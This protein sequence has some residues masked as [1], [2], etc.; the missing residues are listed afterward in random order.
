MP[1]FISEELFKAQFDKLKEHYNQMTKENGNLAIRALLSHAIAGMIEGSEV[2]VQAARETLRKILNE[3]SASLNKDFSQFLFETQVIITLY[4]PANKP[5]EHLHDE[6]YRDPAGRDGV[7]L[8]Q[9]DIALV[10]CGQMS[11]RENLNC[12]YRTSS[13]YGVKEGVV[14]PRCPVTNAFLNDYEIN[15]L[16]KNGVNVLHVAPELLGIEER[17]FR[18]NMLSFNAEHQAEY[19]NERYRSIYKSV[20]TIVSNV[21]IVLTVLGISAVAFYFAPPLTPLIWISLFGS[22]AA[23]GIIDCIQKKEEESYFSVFSTSFVKS[24]AV[25]S[26]LLAGA[27]FFFPWVVGA[28]GMATGIANAITNNLSTI[29][30]I[31]P[32]LTLGVGALIH[33]GQVL[34]QTLSPKKEIVEE[35][36]NLIGLMPH[37]EPPKEDV[38][39]AHTNT[40]IHDL[41]RIM[42]NITLGLIGIPSFIM[43]DVLGRISAYM[44]DFFRKPLNEPRVRTLDDLPGVDVDSQQ[45]IIFPPN[46][47]NVQKGLNIDP[48]ANLPDNHAALKQDVQEANQDMENLAGQEVENAF[49]PQENNSPANDQQPPET[50]KL[51]V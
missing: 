12:Y 25:N 32:A 13:A 27:T 29:L 37:Y 19:N 1:H 38:K 35:P 16:L 10:S 6:Q 48:V 49:Q 11:A 21:L 46:T 36:S 28:S 8:S 41:H 51:V 31:V 17:G 4:Y 2:E 5:V 44:A 47:V 23:M 34:V 24:L 18:E 9:Q 20:N 43:G 30:A 33:A 26:L 50:Q 7:T 14:L 22:S 3:H 39:K 45:N 15:Y 40:I 42:F